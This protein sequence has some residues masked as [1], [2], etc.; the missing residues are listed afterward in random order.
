MEIGDVTA[1]L[2]EP[3]GAS[4]LL[5]LGHGGGCNDWS[6]ELIAASKSFI[7]NRLASASS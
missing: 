2:Y 7:N 6:E 4:S 3:E 1:R 5:L